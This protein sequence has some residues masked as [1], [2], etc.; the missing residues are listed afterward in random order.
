MKSWSGLPGKR[1][2]GRID[3]TVLSDWLTVARAECGKLDRLESA[4]VKIGEM[5]ASSPPDADDTWPCLAVR[6]VME[7]VNSE[8]IFRGF[9]M[10]VMNSRGVTSRSM[11]E[12]GAQERELALKYQKHA[13]GIRAGW[14]MMAATLQ[15]LAHTY[16]SD[17]KRHDERLHER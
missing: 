7:D 1:P 3:K 8:E 10:G 2:D 11:T 13:D 17:A 16:T 9:E 6:D 4:D 14:P 12:G 15:R 5:F